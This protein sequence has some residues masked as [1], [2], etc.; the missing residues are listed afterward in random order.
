MA[1]QGT[2]DIQP[3]PGSRF[4]RSVMAA[5][6]SPGETSKRIARLIRIAGN[7]LIV[8]GAVVLLSVGA[9]YAYAEY[10]EAE[11]T[12][13][14]EAQKS[15]SSELTYIPMLGTATAPAGAPSPTST[16]PGSDAESVSSFV[17][18]SEP[19]QPTPAVGGEQVIPTAP[20]APRPPPTRIVIPKISVDA[21]VV[22]VGSQL[23]EVDGEQ[24][25]IWDVA[26]YA[27]GHHKGSANPGEAGN[28]VITGHD[29]INGEVFRYLENL[30]SGDE[31]TLYA[32]EDQRVYVVQR[33]EL[34]REKGASLEERKQNARFMAPTPD[35]T[36]TL[37]SCWPY[38]IDT[39]RI[40]VI[41]KPYEPAA[42]ANTSDAGTR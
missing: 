28:I 17:P 29:D 41:A 7:A 36:L 5:Q 33:L 19:V 31:I 16:P 30:Q 18:P 13:R 22:E 32:G 20:P 6:D 23:K 8:I 11:L 27:A 2:P 1:E 3:Q 25:I 4:T 38:R 37:I 40:I 14:I 9:F 39:H 24:W 21:K 15:Q 42:S 35:E 10:K 34:V 12:S 26:D